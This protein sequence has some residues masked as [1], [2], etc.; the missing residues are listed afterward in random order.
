MEKRWSFFRKAAEFQNKSEKNFNSRYQAYINGGAVLLLAVLAIW[1]LIYVT[2]TGLIQKS[3]KQMFPQDAV[4][5]IK[6]EKPPGRLMNSYNWGGYLTWNLREY[7]VFVDGRTDL[8]GDEILGKYV[9]VMS[10]HEG[11]EKVLTDYNIDILFIQADSNIEKIAVK[12]GWVINYKDPIAV[13]LT[14]QAIISE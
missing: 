5:W 11:W 1:K 13:I 7:P 14:K 4:N 3:E 6:E 12:S 8:F 10:G 2:D 9:D